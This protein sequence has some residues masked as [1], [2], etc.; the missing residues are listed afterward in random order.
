MAKDIYHNLVKEAL[1]ADGWKI[2]HDPY[3]LEKDTKWEIDLG[4][5]KLIGA[6]KENQKIA[7]EVKTFLKTSF[8]NEFHTVIG[9]YVNYD[10]GLKA[11][12]K[13]RLLYLAVPSFIYK[14]QFHLKSIQRSINGLKVNIVTYNIKSK[15]LEKWIK[16]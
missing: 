15:K 8:S 1:E 2:T 5:E 9:Q 11:M 13:D 6:T 16:H 14:K 10:L 3:Y 12:E 7:V 4:A